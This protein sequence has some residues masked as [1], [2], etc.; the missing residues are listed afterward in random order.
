M[1]SAPAAAQ[2]AQLACELLRIHEMLLRDAPRN[3]AF[4]RAL[5]ANVNP[6]S[7]V[8]DIGSGSGLWAITAAKLGARKVVA[9][10][11]QP[12]L[13]GLIR[14][15]A[16]D[17]GVADRV[18]VIQGDSR[19]VRLPREFDIVISETIGHLIF[20]EQVVEIMID[21]RERFLKPG[22]TLIPDTVT[23]MAAGAHL[24]QPARL[25]AGIPGKFNR[26]ESLMLH[27]PVAVT[28]KKP[29]RLLTTP[30]VLVHAD[31]NRVAAEPA[32]GSLTARWPQQDMERINCFAVWAEAT[33]TQ[34]I[35]VSTMDTPSW[36]ATAYRV[37][38]FAQKC[39]DLEF[40]L[41]LSAHTNHW[42]AALAN[43]AEREAQSYSPEIAAAEFLVLNA[44]D[45]DVFEKMKRLGLGH[46][47]PLS[48]PHE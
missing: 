10:E 3:R 7:A 18:E 41:T 36:S 25:P 37:K 40:R 13:A 45:P 23:L 38:P 19:Q 30:A 22:G 43:G 21:A 2:T 8:L 16:R 9:I 33:L 42:T 14:A 27:G 6:G 48:P 47:T 31:L 39:G 28:D 20:D 4:H 5:K 29:L 11:M 26:L 15:L 17:H 46:L 1:A 24:R 32:L 12:L 34:G 44:P 35:A